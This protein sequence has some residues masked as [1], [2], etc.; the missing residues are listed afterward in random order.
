MERL[1]L[2][3]W[4]VWAMLAAGM[5]LIVASLL[6]SS[7]RFWHWKRARQAHQGEIVASEGVLR[8]GQTLAFACPPKTPNNTASKT[9]PYKANTLN[10]FDSRVGTDTRSLMGN[11]PPTVRGVIGRV[12][13]QRRGLL[14]FALESD[15][16][17]PSPVSSV[18]RYAPN[19]GDMLTLLATGASEMYR[20]E[21]KTQ[22][23]HPDPNAPN[24]TLVTV[25]LQ[26]WLARIQRRQH[27]RA[28]VQAGA[29]LRPAVS[30]DK[31]T[32]NRAESVR[33]LL[34][35]L[36]GGGLRLEVANT[37]SPHAIARLCAALPSGSVVDVALDLPLL[38]GET[39]RV[40]VKSCQRVVARGG[41]ALRLRGE[42]VRLP[43]YQQEIIISHVFQAQRECLRGQSAQ[44]QAISI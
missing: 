7:E 28:S 18:T 33:C 19:V 43:A 24:R 8:V 10:A 9:F 37:H 3:V 13:E 15:E 39:L 1:P 21:A 2:T 35:D 34:L 11:D 44:P 30:G 26:F 29:T 6:Q 27:V 16:I 42:F 38:R 5:A 12:V 31:I 25:K 32:G 17:T 36:S 20:F 22:A 41:L 40:R 4:M 23:V 14:V